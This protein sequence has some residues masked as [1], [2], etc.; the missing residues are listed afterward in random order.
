MKL[1]EIK[2]GYITGSGFYVDLVLSQDGV[3][4]L[5]IKT[6]VAV[7]LDILVLSCLHLI[8]IKVLTGFLHQL[9]STVS[10]CKPASSDRFDFRLENLIDWVSSLVK[11]EDQVHQLPFLVPCIPI[12]RI[13]NLIFEWS[14]L[15]YVIVEDT[16]FVE[17]LCVLFV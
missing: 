15:H 16:D 17:E 1:T 8:D 13:S 7:T 14:H 5:A 10:I 9:V 12:V 6:D 4:S 11:L 2:G 3:A